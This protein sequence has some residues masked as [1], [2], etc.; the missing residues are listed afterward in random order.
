QSSGKPAQTVA[1]EDSEIYNAIQ[2][3]QNYWKE[4]LSGRKRENMII[5]AIDV[6]LGTNALFSMCKNADVHPLAQLAG[7]G[8][9]LMESATRNLGLALGSSSLGLGLGSA[10]MTSLLGAVAGAA[11]SFYITLAMIG[12]MMGFI[13]YYVVPFMPCLYFFF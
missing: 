5:D 11:P 13:M 3:T 6:I 4:A 7:L 12:L 10:S 2:L 1:L 8:R 9:S